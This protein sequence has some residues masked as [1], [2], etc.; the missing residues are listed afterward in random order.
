MG[1]PMTGNFR[2]D[3]IAALRHHLKMKQPDVWS[4]E[5]CGLSDNNINDRFLKL[6]KRL[7]SSQGKN[8][9]HTIFVKE[10]VYVPYESAKV[11][12]TTPSGEL[13]RLVIDTALSDELRSAVS[14]GSLAAMA[15]LAAATALIGKHRSGKWID[16]IGT[17]IPEKGNEAK[18]LW[19]EYQQQCRGK[20][21]NALP[22]IIRN[23]FAS[24]FI[25][26]FIRIADER[27][28]DLCSSLL[29]VLIAVDNVG[30]HDD[31]GVGEYVTYIK[32]MNEGI[33]CLRGSAVAAGL[34]D[35][36]VAGAFMKWREMVTA[37]IKIMAVKEL[38]HLIL[39]CGGPVTPEEYLKMRWWDGFMVPY[40]R[41]P[42]G[43][44]GYHH[45]ADKAGTFMSA[46]KCGKIKRVLDNTF[47]YNDIIDFFSDSKQGDGV[48][49]LLV[50][51]SVAGPIGMAGYAEAL[52]MITDDALACDCGEA[53]HAEAAESAIGIC[54]WY[55]INPRY[56]LRRQ[57]DVLCAADEKSAQIFGFK[58][59]EDRNVSCRIADG[60]L[61]HTDE[62]LPLWA[63]C[64][65]DIREL[66]QRA[67]RRVLPGDITEG[68]VYE[69]CCEVAAVTLKS[70]MTAGNDIK[71]LWALADQWCCFFDEAIS[72]H[73]QLHPVVN[74]LRNIISGIW[75]HHIIG[76]G[77][78]NNETDAKLFI[79]ADKAF[80]STCTLEP[81]R[82][83]AVRR[84]F[85]GVLSGAMEL[86]GF[87]P[88]SRIVDGIVCLCNTGYN[89]HA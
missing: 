55:A 24:V 89:K 46:G 50:A 12:E 62:W 66:V 52:A 14:S 30:A 68:P 11:P 88:Y 49:E 71:S 15:V 2:A 27:I 1:A 76:G 29:I 77:E 31:V 26:Q 79:D 37:G 44:D 10:P 83:V 75:K 85:L 57:L 58:L 20:L 25:W 17:V 43:A 3:Q 7:A 73:D 23:T 65:T 59:Q 48:N 39:S 5:A 82:G 80:R 45:L 72:S 9:P 19:Q 13:C 35:A 36:V 33:T 38:E 74:T 87:N 70:C 21:D 64:R 63:L 47:R 69:R 51:L 18:L 32:V 22:V 81:N 6:L 28:L 53:G 78:G 56:Q 4:I 67:V 40:F 54:V 41:V 61:L 16:T 8:G 42:M 34:R 84:A 86:S 60:D